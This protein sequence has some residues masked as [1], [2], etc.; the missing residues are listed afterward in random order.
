MLEQV[1]VGSTSVAMT[2][3]LALTASGVQ[4]DL[5][6]RAAGASDSIQIRGSVPTSLQE[7][8]LVVEARGDSLGFL[9][10]LVSTELAFDR[11]ST[12]CACCCVGCWAARGQW[13]SPGA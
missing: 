11:G 9:A 3:G 4:L 6:L 10:P 8:D 1:R 7:L 12:T 2:T 13:V 5:A